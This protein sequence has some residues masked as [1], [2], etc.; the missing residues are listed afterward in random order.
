MGYDFNR[1]RVDLAPHPFCTTVG[2]EVRITTRYDVNNYRQ[3][4]YGCLH[5]MGH[6][7]YEFGFLDLNPIEPLRDCSGM[8]MHESQSRFWENQIG[9]SFAF[10]EYLV[11]NA[12]EKFRPM[13]GHNPEELFRR[14]NQAEP[15][16]IRVEADEATYN[17]HI[18][19]RFEIEVGLFRGDFKVSELEEVWNAKVKETLGITVPSADLGV[20]QD[21]HWAIGLVGYFPTYTLGNLIAAQ[22][23]EKMATE[24]SLDD[25]VRK[26]EFKTIL[27]W[28]N[29]SIHRHG[30]AIPTL[31]LVYKVS[32]KELSHQPFV[33]YLKR[34]FQD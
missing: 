18:M 25:L 2:N 1:G 32:G 15:S 34:K 4:M 21:I 13:I 7:L 23:H 29:E 33:H 30:K 27:R 24:F 14:V 3:S 31:D 5:E 19:M 16:F 28:L 11:K 6:A 17:L 12:P 22:L 26:G 10:Q 8:G 20:L 9:R